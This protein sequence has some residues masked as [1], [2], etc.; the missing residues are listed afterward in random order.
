MFDLRFEICAN[1]TLKVHYGSNQ[2]LLFTKETVQS[3]LETFFALSDQIYE[4]EDVILDDA[5][6]EEF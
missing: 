1:G 2:T 3:F 5:K 6:E 4:E